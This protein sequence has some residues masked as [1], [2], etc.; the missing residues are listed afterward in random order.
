MFPHTIT[1]Y[2]V[3]SITDPVSCK[4]CTINHITLLKNV[5]VDE[6]KNV[7]IRLGLSAR[8]NNFVADDNATLYIPFSAAALDP[9]SCSPKSFLPAPDFWRSDDKSPFWTLSVGKHINDTSSGSCFFIKGV[10]VHPDLN[11]EMLETLYGGNLFL[12]SHVETK[13]FGGLQ[14]WEVHAS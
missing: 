13:D 7:K 10:A 6:S 14:H 11:A 3:E 9:V 4:D 12:I 1:L 8:S 2:N 5:L